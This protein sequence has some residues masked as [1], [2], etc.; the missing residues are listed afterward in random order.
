M[1]WQSIDAVPKQEV[2]PYPVSLSRLQRRSKPP[3][4]RYRVPSDSS[5]LHAK[6]V[7]PRELR[8]QPRQRHSSYRAAHNGRE[9]LVD[10]CVTVMQTVI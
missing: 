9:A 7:L 8:A 4:E 3:I 2:L 10:I 5:V 6:E 1:C